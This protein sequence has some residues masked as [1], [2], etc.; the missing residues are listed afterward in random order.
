MTRT[1]P[2]IIAGT[3]PLAQNSY[4]DGNFI[5]GLEKGK[6]VRVV[7]RKIHATDKGTVYV[8]NEFGRAISELTSGSV[9][10]IQA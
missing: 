7:D 3:F 8:T 2:Y 1:G 10:Q 6:F 5:Y 9:F 4:Y